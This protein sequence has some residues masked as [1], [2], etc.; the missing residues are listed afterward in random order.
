MRLRT[1]IWLFGIAAVFSAAPALGQGLLDQ[2]AT[3]GAI[4]A[5]PPIAC[6]A[7]EVTPV[8][9]QQQ[10]YDRAPAGYA[11][12]PQSYSGQIPFNADDNSYVLPAGHHGRNANCG[13]SMSDCG[14]GCGDSCGSCGDPC[15][16]SCGGG[17][18]DCCEC[19]SFWK[20][21]SSVYGE[22]LLLH[23]SNTDTSYAFQQNGTGGA[24]TAPEGRVGVIDFQY[25]SGYRGGFWY[26]LDNCTS[27][28]ASYTNFRSSAADTIT[29][30]RNNG[31]TIQSLLLYPNTINAGTTSTSSAASQA[32]NFQF[33]DVDM[34]R[35]ASGNECHV[36]NYVVGTRYARM[37]QG[38]TQVNQFAQAVG[39]LDVTSTNVFEGAGTKIGFDSKFRAACSNCLFF[40][41]KGFCSVLFGETRNNYVQRDITN[42]TTLARADWQ[43]ERVVPI[44]DYEMGIGWAGCGGHLNLSAGYYNAF[45][46]NMVTPANYVRAVQNSNFVNVGSTM[47]FDGLTARAEYKF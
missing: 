39:T 46:F 40:Y 17:C 3:R 11:S 7:G 13:V 1:S 18:G 6:P 14:T 5:P 22:Y 45:W 26:A 37:D 43:H 41:G 15:G 42:E 33:V 35:L 9:Y 4:P 31:S 12:L 27:I 2:Q 21:R 24:G 29:T 44:L 25:R 16:G 30:L 23:S 34:M 47:A 19:V 32:I 28:G 38:L 10:Q 36:F 20:H 8:G